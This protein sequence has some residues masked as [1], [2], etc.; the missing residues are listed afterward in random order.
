MEATKQPTHDEQLAAGSKSLAI[1]AL[2]GLRFFA[3]SFVLVAH[4]INILPGFRQGPG[5]IFS[6]YVA[7]LA[8]VGMTLFFVLSGFVINYNYKNSI[9]KGKISSYW[10][11]FVS[12][13]AR[14][15]PLYI[16]LIVL[17]QWNGGFFFR[18]SS[19]DA[20]AW[21]IATEASPYYLT[22][23]QSWFFDIVGNN[24][25]IYQF[26]R[27]G[28]LAWSVS[29]EWFFYLTFP[30][31]CTLVVWLPGTISK[32]AAL[33]C[34]AVVAYFGLHF[35]YQHMLTIDAYAIRHYGSVAS[36]QPTYQDLYFRWLVYFSPYSRVLEFAV[37]VVVCGIYF[38]LKQKPVD[39]RERRLGLGLTVAALLLLIATHFSIVGPTRVPFM[40]Q[41]SQ[42]FGYALP[43][44]MFVF[45]VARY[46]TFI[47][48]TLSWR[49]IYWGGEV[50]YSIYLLH[51]LVALMISRSGLNFYDGKRFWLGWIWIVFFLLV[52]TIIASATFIAIERPFRKWLRFVL[53]I[54]ERER[55]SSKLVE[56]PALITKVGLFAMV[57]LLPLGLS[58]LRSPPPISPP[59]DGTIDVVEATYGRSCGAPG[60]NQTRR[61][62][63]TCDGLKTCV[64]TV[65]VRVIGDPAGG[66]AKDFDVAWRCAKEGK[67]RHSV[68][69][70]EAGFGT[71]TNLDCNDFPN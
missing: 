48:K 54:P 23:T 3:A 11:F 6:G 24:N 36:I 38:E 50:S 65:N 52:T 49:P 19:G 70:S 27:V 7:A 5:A 31:L 67:I 18:L 55:R 57:V 1:P 32:L 28:A 16:F 61:L 8:G 64:F 60:G 9:F 62:A 63:L 69:P 51:L 37:G 56:W 58:V 2:T 10:N 35:A 26:G 59:K 46:Q 4:G 42:C 66:C 25:L 41:F 21:K 13:F 17:E 40:Q 45:C 22:L 44:G 39:Q 43:V 15:F 47:S 20:F 68:L 30:F 14:L 29:T 33:A 12:R 53:S 71:K 34:I